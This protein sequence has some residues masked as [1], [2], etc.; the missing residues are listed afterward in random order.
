MRGRR[1]P[2]AVGRTTPTVSPRMEPTPWMPNAPRVPDWNGGPQRLVCPEGSLWAE[3]GCADGGDGGSAPGHAAAN[4]QQRGRV[5]S[6]QAREANRRCFT[7]AQLKSN[8]CSVAGGDRTKG[9]PVRVAHGRLGS[10]SSEPDNLDMP[11]R[12][13]LPVPGDGVNAVCR[14]PAGRAD[15]T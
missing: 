13:F 6:V 10:G 3:V 14:V 12:L 2:S 11:S 15:R 1:Q 9:S 4:T 5:S 8:G 7:G